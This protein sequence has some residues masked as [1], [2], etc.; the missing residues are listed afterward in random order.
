MDTIDAH[1]CPKIKSSGLFGFPAGSAKV[2]VTVSYNCHFS[3]MVIT[4]ADPPLR[5]VV[6]IR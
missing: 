3:A 6:G 1:L 2:V 5:A 4:A